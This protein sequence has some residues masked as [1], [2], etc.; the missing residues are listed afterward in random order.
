MPN[1]NHNQNKAR[2]V[3]TGIGVQCAFANNYEQFKKELR[4]TTQTRQQ[5]RVIS[6]ETLE[7]T[8]QM[9]HDKIRTKT[10][11]DFN[12]YGLDSLK[13]AM[14]NSALTVHDLAEIKHQVGLVYATS[15]EDTNTFLYRTFSEEDSLFGEK[16]SQYVQ[17]AIPINGK[18]TV[19]DSSCSAGGIA[20]GTAL[21]LIKYN[22]HKVVLLGG[23]ETITLMQHSGF[24]S[25]GALGSIGSQPFSENRDGVGLGNASVFL[26]VEEYEYAV[27]RGAPIL[28]ELLGYGI[29]NDA[30]HITAPH[31]EGLGAKLAM[32]RAMKEAGVASEQIAYINGHG[33]GTSTNDSM[34]LLA[35]EETFVSAKSES[36]VYVSSIK[37]LTGHT[38]SAAGV[39]ELAA[40]ITALYEQYVI[41]NFELQQPME[42][43]QNIVLP[44]EAIPMEYDYALSN[45]FAFG[46]NCVSVVVKKLTEEVLQA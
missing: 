33:T 25:L 26:I 32:Q 15:T 38:L 2:A 16:F 13:E 41:P 31:P 34:E 23:V 39:V 22:D 46:G 37:S 24:S 11:I 40:T 45:S 7:R 5:L 43:S 12:E 30:Y 19:C 20:A 18:I 3:V 35:I 8:T 36:P 1:T 17:R 21:D 29:S 27:N 44:T 9:D 14:K 10:L 42:H 4:H 28:G 6:V